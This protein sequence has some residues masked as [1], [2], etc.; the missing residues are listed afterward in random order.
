[1]IFNKKYIKIFCLLLAFILIG[2]E[3][4]QLAIEEIEYNNFEF[5][6]PSND[7]ETK[8]TIWN[9]YWNLKGAEEQIEA[10]SSK[11]QNISF[12][13][14]YFNYNDEVFIPQETIDFYEKKGSIY[15]NRGWNCLLTIVNDIDYGNGNSSTKDKNLINRLVQNE[16]NYKAHAENLI[17]LTKKY[18]FDGLEIDYENIRKDYVLWEKFMNFVN[19][20]N[21]RCKEEN[22]ILR[23]I[24]ETDFEPKNVNWVD[25]PIYSVMCYNLYGS[26]SGPGPKANKEFL[27]SIMNKMSVIPGK[28]DYALANGGFDWDFNNNSEG[29]TEKQAQILVGEYGISANID[30]ESAVKNFDYQNEKGEEHHVWYGDQKTLETWMTWLK[31]NNNYDFSIW[32]VGE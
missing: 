22:L 28:I 10:L 17:S 27:H 8:Y 32:R 24:I 13:A 9:A 21:L 23:I 3:N 7:N 14:A 16:T 15:K 25:G 20:L 30:D 1:M 26:H 12:F 18:N 29:L 31:E 6:V 11:I 5:R 2:R 19:Y 4:K